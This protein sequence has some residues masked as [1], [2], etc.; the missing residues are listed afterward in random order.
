MHSCKLSTERNK[1]PLLDFYTILGGTALFTDNDFTPDSSSLFWADMGEYPDAFLHPNTVTWKR[2]YDAMPNKTL[3]GSGI[4]PDDINQGNLG[5]CWFLAAASSI[6]EFQ[7]RMEKVF[8]NDKNESN[9]ALNR[10]GIYG[11]N[12]FTLGVPHTVIVDD[13]LPLHSDNRTLFAKP[14]DDSSLWV[15]ILEKAFA[16]YYGNYK[17]IHGGLPELAIRTMTGGP[18]HKYHNYEFTVN[19]LWTFIVMHD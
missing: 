13:Y 2:A 19:E 7:G 6:A 1:Q 4:S 17:H 9:S 18:F 16:K 8:L 3:F 5:D 15:V 11:V 14:G 10:P 12:L